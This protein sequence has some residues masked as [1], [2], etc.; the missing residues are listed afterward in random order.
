M[1][2]RHAYIP[3]HLPD[4][5]EAVSLAESHI[6]KG[7]VCF[8]RGEILIFIGYP[9]EAVPSERMDEDFHLALESACERFQP[10]TINVIAPG[11]LPDFIVKAPEDDQ[12]F[13]VHLPLSATGPDEAY[14]VRRASR[15]LIVREARF[16]KEHETLIEDFIAERDL[17][18]AHQ[19]V[20][21]SIAGYL[22]RSRTAKLLEARRDNDL[23]A[24]SILELGSADYGFYLF[25]FR[26]T[27]I[28]VPGASDLLL[29]EMA[30]LSVE[31]GKRYLNLG[32]GVNPGIRR[33]KEK[34]GAIPFLPYRCATIQRRRRGLLA[35]IREMLNGGV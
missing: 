16:R 12:Y 8:S 33:F 20:F 30:R 1:V 28:H 22:D 9:L 34:W 25:N 35:V 31:Q 17:N 24:F 27:S 3:E 5:V 18:A 32:L 4:Y 19:E 10:T 6:H 15:E 29:Y 14:M 13:R 21:R 11:F 2:F 7:Y 26:S 23:V